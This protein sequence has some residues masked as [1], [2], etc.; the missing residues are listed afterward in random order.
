MPEIWT[1]DEIQMLFALKQAGKQYHEIGQTL[2][3]TF[4]LRQYTPDSLKHRWART[5]WSAFFNDR[6]KKKKIVDELTD[7]EVEKQRVI[8]KTIENNQRIIKREAARTHVLIDNIKS[9]IYRLPKPKMSDLVYTPNS[10]HQYT[11][12]HVGVMLSDLHIGAKYTLDDTGGLSEYNLDIFKRRLEKMKRSVLEIV[13]RHRMMYDLP[14]L[15]IFSLG[16][17]VAGAL[18]CGSWNDS[19]IDLAITDQ[20]VEGVQALYCVISTWATAFPK[21]SFYG[22]Y[23]NHG[24]SL[25]KGVGK[26]Y[27]NWDRVCY[28]IVKT[29]LANYSNIEWHIPKAWWLNPTIQGHSFYLCHGDGIRGSMGIPYYGVERAEARIAGIMEQNLDYVLMGHFHN[30]AEI[31]TNTSRVMLNGSFVGADMYSLQDLAKNSS[32]EQKIFGIHKK[33]GITWTYNIYLDE[34]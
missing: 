20:L 28:E 17:V 21:V 12:E 11:A 19:Y 26:S 29:S 30:A 32:P 4:G 25:K 27:D 33:K 3:K 10:K 18:G 31:Q 13:E 8:D 5:D 6:A 24:R 34:D 22:I 15:H 14:E 1:D 23:G 16:D 2:H 7:L 9:A